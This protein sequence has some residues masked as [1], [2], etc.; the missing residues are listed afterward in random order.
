MPSAGQLQDENTIQPKYLF[1]RCLGYH[2]LL[3]HK[4]RS[5]CSQPTLKFHRQVL[6]AS[7]SCE[8]LTFQRCCTS[9]NFPFH[10]ICKFGGIQNIFHTYM[11]SCFL[12][13]C[14]HAYSIKMHTFTLANYH[15][16]HG[17]IFTQL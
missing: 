2:W 16:F 7:S 17:N 4:G 9:N 11:F 12:N 14:R 8:N 6:I 10:N 1:A 3:N 15:Y 5:Q 13:Q